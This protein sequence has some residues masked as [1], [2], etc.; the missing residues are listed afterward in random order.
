M[1]DNSIPFPPKLRTRIQ[2][3]TEAANREI[4][5]LLNGASMALDVPETWV[6]DFDN[7]VFRAPD[8]PPGA[9]V[10]APPDN[11]AERR[12][13][14]ALTRKAG[15]PVPLRPPSSEAPVPADEGEVGS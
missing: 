2:A 7:G 11:R 5:G 9:A 3:I 14:A 13:Q 1:P 12:R 10:A 4:Q 8:A 15:E 6:A